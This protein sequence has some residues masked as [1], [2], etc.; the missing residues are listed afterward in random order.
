M[1]RLC[2]LFLA[3]AAFYAVSAQNAPQPGEP[4]FLEQYAHYDFKGNFSAVI[5]SD[6]ASNYYLLDF[7][8]LSTRFEKIYFMNKSFSVNE[9]VNLGYESGKN[10]VCFKSSTSYP[11]NEVT[12]K[13]NHLLKDTKEISRTW[14]TAA[15]SDWLLKND[16]YK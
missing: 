7:S 15:Q 4:G 12:A 5:K 14:D 11:V 1:K 6:P 9:V 13:F 8:M 10:I 2:F 3:F 16:K